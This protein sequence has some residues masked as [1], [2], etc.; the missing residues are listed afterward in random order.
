MKAYKKTGGIDSFYE[1]PWNKPIIVS[2]SIGRDAW[3]WHMPGVFE[4]N[5]GKARFMNEY[6]MAKNVDENTHI[7]L[8]VLE[9]EG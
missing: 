7:S 2:G 3:M 6:G 5:N 1:I 9:A 8:N 4:R